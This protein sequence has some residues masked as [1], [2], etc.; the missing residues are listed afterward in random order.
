M[1]TLT[2]HRAGMRIAMGAIAGC[3]LS[4]LSAGAVNAATLDEMPSLV[5]KYDAQS[6]DTESGARTLY[7]HLVTA[8][9]Q[10]CPV[11]TG[12]NLRLSAFIRICQEESVARAVQ[13]INNPRLAAVYASSMR[14]G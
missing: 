14:S 5:V 13:Q 4:A 7:R 2:T 8:S 9:R 1:N 10:V 12:R 11:D 6:L 3:L